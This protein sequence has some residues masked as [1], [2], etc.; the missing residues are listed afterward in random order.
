MINFVLTVIFLI[1]RKRYKYCSLSKNKCIL[2]IVSG[3]IF[4]SQVGSTYRKIHSPYLLVLLILT[5]CRRTGTKFKTILLRVHSTMLPCRWIHVVTTIW[6][7]II[8]C[9]FQILT[10]SLFYIPFF[11]LSMKLG[12]SSILF[13]IPK[14]MSM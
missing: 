11:S 12:A 8:S 13:Y 6:L 1:S 10:G 14:L 7:Y 3:F 2:I 4:T 9:G 5:W